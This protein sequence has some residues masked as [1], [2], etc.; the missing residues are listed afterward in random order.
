MASLLE[1]GCK[2]IVLGRA[3]GNE[4]L[5]NRIDKLLGWFNL[6]SKRDQLELFETDFLKPQFGLINIDYECLCQKTEQLIHCASDTSFSE[7][8]RNRV[9]E[10][11]LGCLDEIIKFAADSSASFLHYISTA[12]VSGINDNVIYEKINSTDKYNNVY[13]ESKAEAEKYLFNRCSSLSLPFTILRPSIVYGNSDTGR[14]LKFNA[15]YNHIKSIQFIRDI[16]LNDI[17]NYGGVKSRKMG[18]HIDEAQILNLPFKI[19]LPREGNIN[20]IPINYFTDTAVSL[21]ES[22][23]DKAIYHITSNY[24]VSLKIL[25]D[26]CERLLKIKGIELIY[27][28]SD[29]HVLRN[30]H[31]ELFDRFIEPYRPYLS[32]NKTFDRINTNTAIGNEYPPDFSYEV[33]ERCMNFAISVNWGKT[34]FPNS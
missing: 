4:S 8:N 10:A 30:P 34:L 23:T 19:H 18:I 31:E 14:S 1:K 28:S 9:F 22:P 26:Y 7:C 17:H 15:L 24:L 16:Y 32:E 29:N 33:F 20:M 27:N 3:N 6:N 12:Y 5:E 25:S 2:I 21:L 13:E 11:N